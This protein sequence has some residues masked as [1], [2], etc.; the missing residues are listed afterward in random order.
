MNSRKNSWGIDIFTVNQLKYSDTLENKE[1]VAQ[2]L[3]TY[4][5]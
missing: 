2:Y 1:S 5:F 4:N 3:S